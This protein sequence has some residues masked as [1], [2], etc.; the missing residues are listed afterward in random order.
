ML[1]KT[2]SVKVNID[3][4]N[5]LRKFSIQ[6]GRQL[7]YVYRQVLEKGIDLLLDEN[8]SINNQNEIF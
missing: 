6:E 8:K 5:K 7:S 2:I 4:Y 1:E 3:L